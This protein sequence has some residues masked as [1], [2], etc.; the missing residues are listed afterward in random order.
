MSEATNAL[1]ADISQS[2]ATSWSAI[3]RTMLLLTAPGG[4]RYA[5]LC[6]VIVGE[7]DRRMAGG[8][9]LPYTDGTYL[10]FR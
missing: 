7:R 6:A 8:R 4:P 9:T 1:G 3:F 2:T 5:I 10:R